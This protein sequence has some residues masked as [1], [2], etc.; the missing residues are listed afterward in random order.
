MSYGLHTVSYSSH[1]SSPKVIRSATFEHWLRGLRDREARSRILVRI[2]R[3]A[4]GNAGDVR[5]VG[6]GLSEMRIDCGP[7]YRVYFI[8]QNAALVVLLCGGD[9]RTQTADIRR[10]R[11]LAAQWQEQWHGQD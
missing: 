2:E 4:G 10:A 6:A 1:S 8:E 11:I 9:K 7:G 5:P 3:L